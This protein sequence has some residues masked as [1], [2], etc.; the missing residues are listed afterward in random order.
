VLTRRALVRSSLAGGALLLA[1][2][3]ARAA[4]P[5]S[6]LAHLRLLIGVELLLGD[7]YDQALHGSLDK[8]TAGL[9]T[10]LRA[11]EHAHYNGL[12]TLLTGLG[13][14]PATADDIDFTYPAG[15]FASQGAILKQASKLEAI[16]LGAYL[17][18]VE[19]VQTPS[20]RLP[21][22]QIAANE[23][24]HASALAHAAGARLVGHAFA[25]SLQIGAVSDALSAY[26]A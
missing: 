25:P 19:N 17:G 21:I 23:A 24:Q 16:A 1:P 11:D 14:V 18:A 3:S 10:H 6:D 5:D 4:S 12:A 8:P 7:F 15:T 22:G 20:L 2:L 26:E 9:A 13:Q